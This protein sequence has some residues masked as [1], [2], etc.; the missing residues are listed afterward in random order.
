MRRRSGRRWRLHAAKAVSLGAVPRI[1]GVDL[2]VE[3]GEFVPCAARDHPSVAD[4]GPEPFADVTGHVVGAVRADTLVLAHV[5]G[6]LAG[7]ITVSNDGR[8][9]GVEAFVERE[10]RTVPVIGRRQ[11][12][13]PELR[14]GHRLEPADARDRI[15]PGTVGIDAGLPGRRAGPA[16]RVDESRHGLLPRADLVAEWQ[17]LPV[18]RLAVTAGVDELLVIAVRDLVIGQ[19]RKRAGRRAC[20]R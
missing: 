10:R 7:E 3:V 12:L 16:G 5:R 17:V 8:R 2:V 20:R 14:V 11:F 9:N 1:R 15:V 4:R 13:A 19:D 18:R 6:R